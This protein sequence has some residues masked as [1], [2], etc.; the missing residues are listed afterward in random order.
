[1]SSCS[2]KPPSTSTSLGYCSYRSWICSTIGAICHLH[3]GGLGVGRRD[4]GFLLGVGFLLRL[5]LGHPLQ[6]LA[7]PLFPL[8]GGPFPSLLLPPARFPW[9]GRYFIPQALHLG[10]GVLQASLQG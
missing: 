7:D 10:L 3:D 9:V 5:H 4:P 6:G 2:T 8:T 1:M